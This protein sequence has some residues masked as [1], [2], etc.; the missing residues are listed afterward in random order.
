[1]ADEFIRSFIAIELPAGLVRQ[2]KDFQAALKTRGTSPA[3]WV[4]PGS[5]HLTLKFLGNIELRKLP[6]VKAEITAAVGSSRRFHL[7]TGST[8]FFPDQR[9]PRVFWLGLEGDIQALVILQKAIDEAV[10][11]LG[12]ARETRPFTAHLTLARLKEESNI[13]DKM[14]FVRWAQDLVIEPHFTIEVNSI[15]LM[16]SQLTSKGAIYTRLAEFELH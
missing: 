5:M 10:A 12:F 4:D 1:M 13:S 7:H 16:R 15:A 11:G 2:L 14:G 9:R 3:K 8:G 6:A